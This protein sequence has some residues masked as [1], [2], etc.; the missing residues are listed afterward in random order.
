MG[1]SPAEAN[2]E[3]HG[4]EVAVIGIGEHGVVAAF[5]VENDPAHGVVQSQAGVES[6]IG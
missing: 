3:G 5:E 4:D 2:A 6:K 1:Y